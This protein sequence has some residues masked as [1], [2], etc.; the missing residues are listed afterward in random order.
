MI[1]TIETHIPVITSES[2]PPEQEYWPQSFGITA[3]DKLCDWLE[4]H[5]A[6]LIAKIA[7]EASGY[8][9]PGFD[10]FKNAASKVI[11]YLANQQHPLERLPHVQK[12][13]VLT[14][15]DEPEPDLRS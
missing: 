15:V 3:V 5:E 14:P 9:N 6:G 11:A 7:V 2:P 10:R 1:P 13:F 8:N 12:L 4:E